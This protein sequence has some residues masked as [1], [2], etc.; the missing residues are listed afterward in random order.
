MSKA[1]HSFAGPFVSLCGFSFDSKPLFRFIVS[2]PANGSTARNNTA[3][4][5]PS[6]PV[7]TF[8]QKC[9]PYVK[10]TYRCPPSQ[11]ITSLRLVFP[12]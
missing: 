11:N 12:R 9:I 1:S 4:P 7:T 6:L 3:S 2:I 5:I 10:Y 8:A